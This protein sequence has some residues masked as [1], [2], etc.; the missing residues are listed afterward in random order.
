[1]VD[2][3]RRSLVDAGWTIDQRA[4]LTDHGHDIVATKDKRRLIIEAKGA[5]SAKP[6]SA[7]FGKAFDS[8]Q[9]FDHVAKAILKALRAVD[10]GDFGAVALPADKYHRR[11]IAAVRVSLNQVGIGV[12][13]VDD[14]EVVELDAPWL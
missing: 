2:S 7:R 9:V 11:E 8:G 12:F 4:G 13:W 1:M 14:A 5:G 6:G 3:V 10:D